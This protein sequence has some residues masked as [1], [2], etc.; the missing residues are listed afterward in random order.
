MF[1]DELGGVVRVSRTVLFDFND[2][3]DHTLFTVPTGKNF[4]PT[5]IVIHT[6][7]ADMA[8]AVLSAGKSD[9]K[10]DFVVTITCSG[11]STVNDILVL[12]PDYNATP[13]AGSGLMT[14]M[15]AADTF[16]IDM[17]TS[18]GGACTGTVDLFGYLF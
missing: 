7:S 4:V 18:A 8:N 3:A 11:A 17:L 15:V 1:L 10:T 9:A 12:R 5:L 2:T 14:I 16:V 13:A 6:L